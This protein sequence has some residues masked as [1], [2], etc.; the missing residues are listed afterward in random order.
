MQPKKKRASRH[1]L[2]PF[3]RVSHAFFSA[4]IHQANIFL[5]EGLCGKRVVV[6]IETASQAPAAVEHEGAHYGS[7]N[8]SG[9]FEGLSYRAELRAQRLASEVLD[10]ILKWICAGQNYGVRWPC[11]W[12]LR[13]HA[14]EQHAVVGECIESRGLHRLCAITA[15]MIGSQR[16]DSNQ[17]DIRRGLRLCRRY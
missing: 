3:D 16:V 4:T 15:D 10:A 1:L 7:G 2:Q 13:N 12:N 17:D 9:L 6:K 8:V 14:F 11:K 5:L